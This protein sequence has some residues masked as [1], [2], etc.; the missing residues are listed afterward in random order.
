MVVVIGGCL[1]CGM[2]YEIWCF[3]IIWIDNN[4]V[5]LI[6]WCVGTEM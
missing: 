1:G 5:V 6:G 4:K 3:E 2:W